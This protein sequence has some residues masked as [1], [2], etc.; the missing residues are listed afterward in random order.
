MGEK[1]NEHMKS[2]DLSKLREVIIDKKTKIYIA[3]GADVEEA[4]HRY[5]TRGPSRRVK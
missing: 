4:K 2:P 3:F 5:L 1:K